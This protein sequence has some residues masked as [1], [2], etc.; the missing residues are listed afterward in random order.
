MVP[1]TDI[2]CCRRSVF[3]RSFFRGC[4]TVFFEG[5]L[6][7]VALKG[8]QKDNPPPLFGGSPKAQSCVV[9]C[10]F[11]GV[12]GVFVWISRLV[13][14]GS[15]RLRICLRTMAQSPNGALA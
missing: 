2:L 14:F 6:F 4:G 13:G 11:A 5:A 3:L 15:W 8:N 1:V 7:L 10:L 9:F 12:G